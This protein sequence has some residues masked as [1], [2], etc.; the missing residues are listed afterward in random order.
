MP[1]VPENQR[2][3]IRFLYSRDVAWQE[4]SLRAIAHL[5]KGLATVEER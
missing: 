4:T 3:K 5:S 2:Y 1:V